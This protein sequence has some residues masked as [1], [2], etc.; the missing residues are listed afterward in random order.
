MSVYNSET[1]NIIEWDHKFLIDE[2]VKMMNENLKKWIDLLFLIFWSN[3]TILCRST[4]KTLYKLL[5]RCLC[6]L[7]IEA[8]ILMWSTIA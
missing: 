8:W 1:N 7:F 4:D 3:W 2:L 5:Y 6:I